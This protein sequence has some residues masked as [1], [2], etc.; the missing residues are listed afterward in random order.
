M[1]CTKC[2]VQLNESARFCSDCGCATRNTAPNP[3]WQAPPK[4]SRPRDDR[5]I[6]GVC[7][8]FA[9]YMDVDVTLVRLIALVLVFCPP[10]IG[11]ISYLVAWIVMPN[12]PRPVQA[13]QQT[14]HTQA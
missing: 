11:L 4:L 13:Y 5:K 7:A 12:D 2:G 3:S 1:Y 14:V 8:G 9:R 6:A 10:S